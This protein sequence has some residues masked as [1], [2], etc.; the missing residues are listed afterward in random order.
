MVTP[1]TLTAWLND[2]AWPIAI[3]GICI[4]LAFVALKISA[5]RRHQALAH[6]REGVT[7]TTF[8]KHLQVYGF[9]PV[10]TGAT[11]RYLQ[12]VQLVQFPILAGDDLVEDL[13]LDN[14]DIEQ[15]VTELTEALKREPNPGL[16]H[17]PL[18][19]VEDLVRLLQASPRRSTMRIVAAA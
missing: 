2:Q 4:I 7:E 14:D 16:R 3:I 17:T 15:T 1:D 10:I 9:D 18:V 11:Y 12:E 8:T 5:K 13:G 19:T 6:E